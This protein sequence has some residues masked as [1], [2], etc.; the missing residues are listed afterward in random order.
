[1]ITTIQKIKVLKFS[2]NSYDAK[3]SLAGNCDFI[4]TEGLV[5]E[6]L[7]FLIVKHYLAILVLHKTA[8]MKGFSRRN[9]LPL[10]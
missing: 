7:K 1:M 3:L 8:I 10:M 4:D 6:A 9:A 5:L 2:L